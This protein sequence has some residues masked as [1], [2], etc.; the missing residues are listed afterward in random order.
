ME[1]VNNTNSI[2]ENIQSI[3]CNMFVRNTTD[4]L[5]YNTPNSSN[6][7]LEDEIS[8]VEENKIYTLEEQKIKAENKSNIASRDGTM[9]SVRSSRR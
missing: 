5:S 7:H 3:N 9:N 2:N 1:E 6:I 4:V 8:Y